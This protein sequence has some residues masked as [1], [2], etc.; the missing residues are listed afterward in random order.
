ML[1]DVVKDQQE[2]APALLQEGCSREEDKPGAV[3]AHSTGRGAAPQTSNMAGMGKVT[4]PINSSMV[5]RQ[6]KVMNQARVHPDDCSGTSMDRAGGSLY[7][8]R[9]HVSPWG[10]SGLCRAVGAFRTRTD[11]SNALYG[12]V[13]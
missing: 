5:I 10:C 7:T 6:G 2:A 11:E 13:L 9:E 1:R 12:F 8:G 4:G 3:V